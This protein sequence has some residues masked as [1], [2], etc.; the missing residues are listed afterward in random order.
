MIMK[1]VSKRNKHPPGVKK[2]TMDAPTDSSDENVKLIKKLE[3]QRFVLN[4][5]LEHSINQPDPIS[6]IENNKNHSE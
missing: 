1:Q 6:E 4:M 3:L 2:G 5:L